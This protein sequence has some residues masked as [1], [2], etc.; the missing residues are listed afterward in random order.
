MR[1]LEPDSPATVTLRSAVRARRDLVAHRVAACN[2][3]RAHL[4]NCFPGAVGLFAELDS[5]WPRSAIA[6]AGSP[7]PSR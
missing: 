3:L 5:C 4:Q 7:P 6:A 2:Q 1:P